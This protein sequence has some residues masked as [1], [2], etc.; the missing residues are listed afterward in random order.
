M[1]QH[2]AVILALRYLSQE[3][4]KFKVILDYIVGLRTFWDAWSPVQNQPNEQ[5]W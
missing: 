3:D 1:L 2:L 5:K 4:P